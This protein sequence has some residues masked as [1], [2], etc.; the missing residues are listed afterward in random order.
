MTL[1]V[2]EYQSLLRTDFT[3]FIERSFAELNPQAAYLSSPYIE[4]I[5]SKLEACRTGETTRLIIN[6]PPRSLKSHT[7]SV[8]FVAWLLGHKPAGQIICASYGQELADS[9]PGTAE[10]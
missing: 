2:T 8:A 6:L 9:T 3:S 7:A 4:L 5:A 1:T 10:P